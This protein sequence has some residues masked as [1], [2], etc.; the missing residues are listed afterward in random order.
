[1]RRAGV[2]VACFGWGIYLVGSIPGTSALPGLTSLAEHLIHLGYFVVFCAVVDAGFRALAGRA[3][4]AGTAAAVH[5][6]QV[7]AD[8]VPRAAAPGAATREFGTIGG[9]RYVAHIDGSLDLETRNG[10]RRFT[11]IEAALAHMMRAELAA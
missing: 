7:A 9:C 10:W 1:M 4:A 2:L 3:S 5:K 11:S 6:L 8:A